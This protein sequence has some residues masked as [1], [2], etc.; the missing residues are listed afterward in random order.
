MALDEFNLCEICDGEVEE[1]RLAVGLKTCALCAHR[2]PESP[3]WEIEG[4]A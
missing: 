2:D 1:P 3:P 4:H